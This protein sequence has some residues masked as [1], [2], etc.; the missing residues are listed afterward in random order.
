MPITLEKVLKALDLLAQGRPGRVGPERLPT[1]AF[2]EPIR[3]P[4]PWVDPEGRAATAL[5]AR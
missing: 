3:V 1:V 5:H 2:P 4:P